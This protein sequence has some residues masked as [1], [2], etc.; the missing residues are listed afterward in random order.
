MSVQSDYQQDEQVEKL[1][2]RERLERMLADAEAQ[3]R[4]ARA[5]WQAFM[6]KY[7]RKRRNM[8]LQ[9]WAL[10]GISVV[11]A[12]WNIHTDVYYLLPINAFGM[13]LGIIFP[14]LPEDPRDLLAR[15]VQ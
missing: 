8:F 13:L 11:C 2:L 9:R 10:I 4:Q 15:K 14:Q 5:E 12:A 7:H 3:E 1:E 6:D